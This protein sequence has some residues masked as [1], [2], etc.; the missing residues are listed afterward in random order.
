MFQNYRGGG[1]NGSHLYELGWNKQQRILVVVSDDV[2]SCNYH[3]VLKCWRNDCTDESD[4]DRK[5]LSPTEDYTGPLLLYVVITNGKL[6]RI[7]PVAGGNQPVKPQRTSSDSNAVPRGL[8]IAETAVSYEEVVA[9]YEQDVQLGTDNKLFYPVDLGET[10]TAKSCFYL[11]RLWKR[12]V[13]ESWNQA[14]P[15]KIKPPVLANAKLPS[16]TPTTCW[17]R[18]INLRQLDYTN[19]TPTGLRFA[20]G[21]IRECSS[22][23]GMYVTL[24][25][26][27]NADGFL[28]GKCR[29]IDTTV[30]RSQDDGRGLPVGTGYIIPNVGSRQLRDYTVRLLR[31]VAYKKSGSGIDVDKYEVCLE[32]K[33]T[34]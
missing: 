6:W 25:T 12:L 28:D 17:V 8:L 2:D 14:Q 19:K 7:Y 27:L 24:A 18:C 33:S 10:L 22:W 9:L 29:D 23:R 30:Y 34:Q 21:V 15:L 5:S 32:D 31:L 26:W 4:I 11:S 3:E 1:R 13:L 20:G 16:T